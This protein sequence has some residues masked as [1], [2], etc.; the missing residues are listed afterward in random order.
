M[1]TVHR[2]AQ[3]VVT[4]IGKGNG[5]TEVAI[6]LAQRALNWALARN[7][8]NIDPA[9][10]SIERYC[11]ELGIPGQDMYNAGVSLPPPFCIDYPV[12]LSS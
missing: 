5:D 10:G 9:S 4:Y 8:A 2:N 6:S 3:R 1:P 12:I 11:L 7:H